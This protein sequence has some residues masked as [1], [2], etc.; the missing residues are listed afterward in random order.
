MPTLRDFQEDTPQ[1]IFYKEQHAVQTYDFAT[2]KIAEYRNCACNARE[3]MTMAQALSLLDTFVDPSDPD[4]SVPNSHHAYQTAEKIRRDYPDEHEHQI[5]ALI[6]D[7]GKILFRFGEPSYAI[8]GD[9]YVVGC[10]FPETI[11]FYETMKHNPD[12]GHP[13]YSTENGVYQPN[14]GLDNLVITFG[15]DEYLYQVLQKNKNHRLMPM[16]QKIIRYHSLYPWHTGGAY[17]H[18][19]TDSDWETYYNVLAFNTYD[20]YSK[21][22]EFILTDEIKE[23]YDK[24]LAKYFPEPLIW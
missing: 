10:K 9:T 3:T 18:L 22:D 21:T 11:V 15:H 17:R 16:Y 20:L 14:C 6:H 7:L 8:V 12:F 19:M 24:L 1:Y 2:R 13:V 4:V 5:C 23:Y